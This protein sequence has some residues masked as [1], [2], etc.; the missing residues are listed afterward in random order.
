VHDADALVGQVLDGLERTFRTQRAD[1]E[2]S[3]GDDCASTEDPRM[4]FGRYREFFDR[5]L[6]L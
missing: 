4:A 6:S 3:L 5:L 1:L 2:H